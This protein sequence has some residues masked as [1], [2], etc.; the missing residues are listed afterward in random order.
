MFWD[1]VQSSEPLVI[2]VFLLCIYSQPD[3]DPSTF[4]V[5]DCP[6]W[7]KWVLADSTT[8]LQRLASA[9]DLDFYNP[10]DRLWLWA[11]LA[12]P[13]EVSKD[14]YIFFRR[15]GIRCHD[16]QKHLDQVL[17]K[18]PHQRVNMR[19]KRDSVNKG[20]R[21]KKEKEKR[22]PPNVMDN[23]NSDIEFTD[24]T[25]RQHTIKHNR[26]LS[27]LDGE[28]SACKRLRST[29]PI[30]SPIPLSS[31]LSI[32]ETLRSLSPSPNKSISGSSPT[33]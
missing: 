12:Y 17:A 7:P 30:I 27:P 33:P 20:L 21:A 11:D 32:S 25:P 5:L 18:P 13:H 1:K 6:A 15:R 29:S 23:N 2:S 4:S 16:F 31:P 19:G 9:P 8:A 14:S 22:Q 26:S 3:E 28:L 24:V 10:K